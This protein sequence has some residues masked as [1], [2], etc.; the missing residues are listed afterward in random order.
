MAINILDIVNSGLKVA[1]DTAASKIKN[2]TS[3]ASVQS[4]L[5]AVT[6]KAMA[7]QAAGVPATQAQTEATNEVAADM[8]GKVI[9]A[10]SKPGIP[11][12]TYVAIGSGILIVS[13]IVLL[14]TRP[15]RNPSNYQMTTVSQ[16]RESFWA[17]M[18]PLYREQY[19]PSKRQNDYCADIRMAWVGYIDDLARDGIISEALAQRVTL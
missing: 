3:T 6:Q 18:T 8:A 9:D 11:I 19:Q 16:V 1:N 4:A 10:A 15:K 12:M 7:K 13:G 5:T 14:M 17:G 2:L